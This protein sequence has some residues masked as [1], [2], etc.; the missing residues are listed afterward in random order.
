MPQPHHLRGVDH[1]A[2]AKRDQAIRPGLCQNAGLFAYLLIGRIRPNAV[3]HDI[4]H[5]A[6]LQCAAQPF[7]TSVLDD[8]SGC[9]DD[10]RCFSEATQP[11]AE[12]PKHV[13]SPYH[14]AWGKEHRHNTL[15]FLFMNCPHGKQHIYRVCILYKSNRRAK[16]FFPSPERSPAKPVPVRLK[17]GTP[18][19]SETTAS[20]GSALVP[21]SEIVCPTWCSTKCNTVF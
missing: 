12:F 11:D 21:P 6:Q 15:T 1:G 4:R 3:D 7:Q 8:A 5:A 14:L 20:S 19:L 17:F 9:A 16:W 18:G 13:G 10:D 2:A